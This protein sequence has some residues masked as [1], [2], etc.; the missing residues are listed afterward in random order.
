MI[1]KIN[2][3]AKLYEDDYTEEDGKLRFS[4]PQL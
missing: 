2:V 3:H 4:H 1:K